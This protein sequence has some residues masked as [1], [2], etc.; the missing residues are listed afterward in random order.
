MLARCISRLVI[1]L[2]IVFREAKHL[3][4]I[5]VF[6]LMDFQSRSRTL[7]CVSLITSP[8]LK[9][10]HSTVLATKK[11]PRSVPATN[12]DNQLKETKFKDYIQ[13]F[14]MNVVTTSL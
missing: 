2:P 4:I 11:E 12:Q 10:K 13:T 8:V 14:S 1:Q 3:T 6:I 9:V 5:H 7:I